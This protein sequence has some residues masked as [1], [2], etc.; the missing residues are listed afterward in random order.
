[1]RIQGRTV[2]ITGASSGIG[3]ATAVAVARRGG[4]PLLLARR[5]E[6]LDD[7]VAQIGGDARAYAVDCGDRGAVAAAAA[8]IEEEVGVPDAIVNNAGAGRFLFFDKT[9]PEEFE[10]MMAAPYFA[11][12]YV[13][14]AFLPA[15]IARGRGHVVM[16]NSPIGFLTWQGAAGYAS[17]RW[18]LRGLTDA[19]HADLRG[20]GIG[21]SQVVPAKVSSGY[22]EHNPGA[23]E[24]IPNIS[25]IVGTLT[26]EHVAD[27]IVDSV[28][29][30]RR[31]VFTPGR[32]RLLVF[33]SRLFPGLSERLVLATGRRRPIDGDAP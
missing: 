28:E 14:R 24:G 31:L 7:L 26:P 8:R 25:R 1:V 6:Q 2:L 11:A 29:R 3:A 18:A 27:V 33:F 21:V 13:T 16:V 23:A 5:Q 4:R 17:A 19:L 32:L 10:R 22:F 12:V 20:T 30:G 9:E 15:M